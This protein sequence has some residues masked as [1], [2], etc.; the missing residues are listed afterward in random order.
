MQSAP[1]ILRVA[2]PSPLYR[3]FD[4]LPPAGVDP[5]DLSPG[6]R[7]RIP[8]GR[9]HKVG[10]LVALTAE[11]DLEPGRLKPASALLDREPVLPPDILELARWAG[12]YYRAPPGDAFATAL[13]VLLRRGEPAQAEGERLWRLSPAGHDASPAELGRAH[14]QAAVLARLQAAPDGLLGSDGLGDLE[15][16]WR[17]ALR[18]LERRGWV[19]TEQRPCL[20]VAEATGAPPPSL[21][22]AQQAAVEAVHQGL[23][24]FGAFLLEGVTGSGKTEV[25]LRLIETV[26]EAGRQVLILVPEIGLTPQL[27]RRFGRLGV[28]L[29]VLHSGLGERERLCAWLAARDGR[30]PLVIGTRSAVFTPLARP[31]LI[32]VDEEHD[33]SLKQQEGFRYHARDLAVLRARHADVPVLLGSATPS[34][35][36]LLNVER[37]RYRRLHLPERAGRALHPSLRLLDVRSQPMEDGLSAQLRVAMGEHLARGGQ[38]LIFLNRRGYAPTLLCH[39]C[40]WVAD[41]DRCDRHYTLHQGQRILRC[42]HCGAQRPLPSQCPHCGSPDLRPVGQGTERLERALE[43]HF[44]GESVLRIDRDSTRRKGALDDLLGRARAGHARI[45]VGTQMLA[46]GHHFPDVTL[47]AIIDADQALFSADFRGPERMAQQLIQVA[48]RAGRAKRPGE[49]L[50]QTHHPDHPLLQ[51]LLREGYAPFAAAAL[52]ERGE[53]GLPPFGNLALLRAEAADAAAPMAFLEAAREL[54]GA[55][56]GVML[57]GPLPAPMPRRAGRHRAQLLLQSP[58]RA[59]L[60]RLLAEWVGRLAELKQARQVRWSIDVD[61]MEMF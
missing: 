38:V 57:F 41:C 19:T 61:P 54:A 24:G 3:L 46:K 53:T 44:P 34:L 16:D 50:I 36:S 59:P 60:Q 37:G 45:L 10:L 39:D 56:P 12:D 55:A 47:V 11:S 48:G 5:A 43:Q 17:G 15:G 7:L 1:S 20:S 58:E 35:E 23:Q 14:R 13:P 40:G 4:Y 22:A 28:P 29:A 31:G 6:V 27:V 52:A 25:Y 21:N 33:L 42:H 51:L 8:F 9:G 26:L 2:V 18:S 49:V 30:A 32:V